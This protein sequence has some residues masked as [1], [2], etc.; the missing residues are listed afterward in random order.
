M[1]ILTII[2][3]FRTPDL[4]WR[5]AESADAELGDRDARIVIVDNDSGDGSEEKL[6]AALAE[7]DSKRIE[8]VQ[9]GHNGGFGAG[10]N[11]ALRAALASDDPPELFYLL[12]SDAFPDPG[13]IDAL[14]DA[15]AAHPDVG[16]A[17]SY[18]HGPDGEPHRTAFRFPSILSELE[19]T[20]RLGVLSRVLEDH[21][22][23]PPLP[24]ETTEVDWLAG[25]SMLIRREVLEE[26]GLFDETFFLY[27]EETDLCLRA[28]EAGWRTLYVRES[29]ITHIGSVSTGMKETAQRVPRFWLDSR[30]YFFRK[31]HGRLYQLAADAVHVSGEVSWRLRAALQRKGRDG[32]RPRYLR[33]FVDHALG[34]SRS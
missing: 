13:S 31:N 25:C 23:A 33:D 1:E 9:S 19:S 16:I 5:A 15:L 24:T 8:V 20:V 30:R 26:V 4:A 27:F 3:N 18:I 17:G 22:I 32:D 11:V 34:R 10:N 2:V 29:E 7:S 12:N 14:V 21:L 28:R 6:R